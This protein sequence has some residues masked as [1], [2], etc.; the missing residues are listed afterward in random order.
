[1]GLWGGFS[2][3]DLGLRKQKLRFWARSGWTFIFSEG[4]EAIEGLTYYI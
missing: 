4:D 1:M 2:D 3:Y